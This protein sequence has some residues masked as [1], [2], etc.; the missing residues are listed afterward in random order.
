MHKYRSYLANWAQWSE[1]WCRTF[2]NKWDFA[3]GIIAVCVL[4]AFTH[5]FIDNLYLHIILILKMHAQTRSA[6]FLHHST[7]KCA[8]KHVT[9]RPKARFSIFVVFYFLTY[10]QNASCP[11]H[12]HFRVN[13]SV[14]WLVNMLNLTVTIYYLY[15]TT[16]VT[17]KPFCFLS[18]MQWYVK[19]L[20]KAQ[21]KI[22]SFVLTLQFSPAFCQVECQTF[23][24]MSLKR[25]VMLR[26]VGWV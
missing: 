10:L 4:G 9:V 19:L 5:A 12:K 15:V 26:E 18:F 3:I 23:L 2:F 7:P 24:V 22:I 13:G 20:Q 17:E 25:Y 16:W 21:F 11:S 6:L 8:V 1:K 14:K